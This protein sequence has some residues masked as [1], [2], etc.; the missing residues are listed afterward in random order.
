MNL[1]LVWKHSNYSKSESFGVNFG[2]FL[3]AI[4]ACRAHVATPTHCRP[5]P[6]RSDWLIGIPKPRSQGLWLVEHHSPPQPPR[7]MIGLELKPC[8][9][10]VIIFRHVKLSIL[11]YYSTGRVS[12]CCYTQFTAVYMPWWLSLNTLMVLANSVVMLCFMWHLI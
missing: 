9:F 10:D 11:M 4:F 7:N 3:S 8:Q 12:S 6:K 2:D 1:K 5:R